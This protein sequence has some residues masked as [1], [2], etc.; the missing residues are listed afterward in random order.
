MTWALEHCTGVT[1]EA[2]LS[3]PISVP[4][5]SFS[6]LVAAHV[7]KRSNVELSPG[8]AIFKRWI[9]PWVTKR[10]DVEPQAR[11]EGQDLI[12]GPKVALI[13]RLSRRAQT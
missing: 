12:E 7:R 2:Q 13:A 6:K 11:K 1:D 10:Q 9:M 8:L 4:D 3:S 5:E